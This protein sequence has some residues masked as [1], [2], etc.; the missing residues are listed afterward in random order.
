[1]GDAYPE[2]KEHAAEIT[3]VV[4]VEEERF[5]ETLQRGLKEF[6][7]L[8][9]GDDDLRRGRLHAAR[10]LRL[11]D[12]ADAGARRG[13][14]AR[15]VDVD[16]FRELME[17]H[18]EISRAGGEKS[19]VQRAAEFAQSA[20][21]ESR[22]VGYEQTD[23]LTQIGALEDL[24]D[25]TF[26]CKLRE[27]PFYA[28]SGG[29]VTDTGELI[30]EATGAT[31]ALHAAYKIGDD[32]ALVFEGAGF[33]AGD[34]VRAVVAWSTRFPTM[35]NHTATH[36]LHQALRDVL[37]DHVKQAG[38]A[39]RPDKLRFDFTHPQALTAEERAR[40]ERIVNEK[41]FEAM[42]V[43]TF[44]TPIAE[45]RK[46]GAM[47][48]FGEKYGE[49]VRVVEI[50]GYSTEL[51]G[52]THVRSTAE[53]GPFVLLSEGSVGS[54]ARRIEAVTS[55]EAWT[56]L[57]GRS[58]ELEEVRGELERAAARGEE[59]A[60]GGRRGHGRR[61]AR[62]RG[63]RRRQ[64]DRAGGRRA[65]GRRAAR[66]LRPLQAAPARRRRSCSARARTAP[67]TS[68]RTS[69]KR[70]PRRFAPATSSARSRR[71]SAAA[72]AA[73]RRWPAPAARTRRSSPTRSPAPAS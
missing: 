53:I 36:L 4:R 70:S 11:P 43:R 12:R 54:G 40:V 15:P 57:H 56:V 30:H 17:G 69:T 37:G 50:D 33:A 72:A 32:Q 59:A 10:H 38:S 22:F 5:R 62:G 14:R 46:L 51:C 26:L 1:M 21:F 24:G 8:A 39:V 66:P 16:R 64:R 13:A 61:R 44:E 73:A 35:A 42:P 27:T 58:R 18:R 63:D 28:D 23:V 31:A 48:L 65:L 52:G 34:R 47:A 2:L 71:S 60:Q 20:G 3:R 67:S 41:V 55:G 45:A 19:D 6:E 49:I 68:S 29:Q 7:E 25:G 9:G